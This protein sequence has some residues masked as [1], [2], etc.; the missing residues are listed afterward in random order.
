MVK[1]GDSYFSSSLLVYLITSILN[2][3]RIDNVT[4]KFY[5]DGFKDF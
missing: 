5:D 1:V 2:S 4:E 3:K